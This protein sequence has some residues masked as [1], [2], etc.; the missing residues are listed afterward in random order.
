M[1]ASGTTQPDTVVL[2]VSGELPSALSIFLQ[3]SALVSGSV[4]FGDGLR[5]VGGSLKRLY[6]KNASAGSVDAPGAGDP[7]ITSRSAA[8]GDPIAP[9]TSRYYQTYYRDPNL[10]FCPAPQGNSWN[11]TNGVIVAW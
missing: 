9:G 6:V 3:G 4:G 2:H 11:V 7:S 10:A 1:L 5:C 8:L